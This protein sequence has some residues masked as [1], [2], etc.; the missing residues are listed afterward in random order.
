[1]NPEAIAVSVVGPIND[2]I[3]TSNIAPTI[4]INNIF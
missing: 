4:K 2:P 3:K 1:V